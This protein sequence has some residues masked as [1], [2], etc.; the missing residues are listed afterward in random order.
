MKY[1]F[2]QMALAQETWSWRVRQQYLS[3][4]KQKNI[5]GSEKIRQTIVWNYLLQLC[6]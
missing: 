3:N 6:H 4:D 1:K 2:I 5:S